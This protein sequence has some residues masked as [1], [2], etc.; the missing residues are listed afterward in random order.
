MARRI[1]DGGAARGDRLRL[2]FVAE[3]AKGGM[4]HVDLV[5]R[6]ERGFSRLYARKRLRP[7]LADEPRAREM[8]LREAHIAGSLRH[9]NVVAVVDVG[10]DE[11]GPFL[12]ME[13]IDGLPLAAWIDDAAHRGDA[14]PLATC[15]KV[16]RDVA[17]GLHAAHEL[18]TADGAP[19]PLVHRDLSPS[20]I[21]VGYDGVPRVTDFGVAKILDPSFEETQGILRGKLGYMA[22]EV[23]TFGAVDRRADLFSL[24]VVMYEMLTGR[25]LYGDAD[26][27]ARANRILHEPPLDPSLVRID[28]PAPLTELLFDLLAKAPSDRPST[29]REVADRLDAVLRELTWDDE[30]GPTMEE[31]V[32]ERFAATRAEAQALRE[33]SVR[34]ALVRR[35][36][37]RRTRTAWRWAGAAMGLLLA[38]AATVAA[39]RGWRS[40]TQP[41]PLLPV[42]TRGVD[43]ADESRTEDEP[44]PGKAPPAPEHRRVDGHDTEIEDQSAAASRRPEPVDPERRQRRP[45]AEGPRRALTSSSSG[46]S[47]REDTTHMSS[48]SK[49]DER[50][51]SWP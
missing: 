2:L 13:Y 41:S 47:R 20:N 34:R 38:L 29:A 9:P 31:L 43:G 16:A 17:L 24:G 4:G 28:V 3:I 48:A 50:L 32:E 11:A 44:P 46:A 33:D 40:G 26:P 23:L 49:I 25:R 5:L 27:T 6:T 42:D 8:F 45:N 18:R 22:P 10:D 39:S 12:L 21:L 51:W 36:Q 7:A 35:R 19:M 1:Q 37:R 14:L 30:A 15:V